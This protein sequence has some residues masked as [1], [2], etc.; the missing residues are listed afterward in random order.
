MQDMRPPR[1]GRCLAAWLVRVTPGVLMRVMGGACAGS[2]LPRRLGGDRSLG[3]VPDAAAGRSA[4]YSS[5]GPSW[6]P[7]SAVGREGGI[8][9]ELSA[10]DDL[11]PSKMSLWNAVKASSGREKSWN[12]SR[13]VARCAPAAAA[14]LVDTAAQTAWRAAAQEGARERQM[15][16]GS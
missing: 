11:L 5:C 3:R 14:R 10:W 2:A 15:L 12:R 6:G 9:A 8:T 7:G 4:S 1:R 13:S 16:P